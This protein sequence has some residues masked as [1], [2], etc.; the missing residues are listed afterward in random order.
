MSLDILGP[1]N[2]PNAVTTRPVD[3]RTGTFG[4]ADSWMK[5]CSSAT[6]NDGTKLQ[7]GLFNALLGQ[8]RNLVRG[9][10]QT[11]ASADVVTQDNTDDSMALKAVQHL[12]QRGQPSYALDTSVT[13]GTITVALSPAPPEYKAGMIVRVK[14]ANIPTASTQINLN[15]L[16]NK[17][18]VKSG[19]VAL[20]G[21]EW[22]V[23]DIVELYFDGTTFYTSAT[24]AS[25]KLTANRTIYINASTGS[26]T[27]Y[28]G[29]AA[30]VS[31]GHGPLATL[32]AAVNLAFSYSPS[33]FN[34]TVQIAAGTYT[35]CQTPGYPGPTLI[36]QGASM[37]SVI[38]GGG[39]AGSSFQ[40][41]GQNSMTVN[42]AT[43]QNS[44]PT[45]GQPAFSAVSGSTLSTN[46]T[47]N[48]ACGG[49][50]FEA[51]VG[52]TIT[53][54]NHTFNGGCYCLF[55][56]QGGGSIITEGGVSYVI[57]VSLTPTLGYGIFAS[58]CGTI[59]L[60]GTPP[61]FVGATNL[62]GGKYLASANGVISC[63]GNGVNY[64]PGSAAGSLQ[65]GGQITP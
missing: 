24:S 10:G 2:A 56:A 48:N 22:A 17:A 43:V 59:T 4:A 30:T 42:N 7:A 19:G 14:M 38:V 8:L 52:A 46:N 9:N 62:V 41:A 15:T 58:D 6:A 54:G 3:T 61:T 50:V 31:G 64:W 63:T 27:L 23:G 16:G 18:V 28:D 49:A 21:T 12:I 40:V 53:P 33:Q 20:S 1:A 39:A 44:N 36:F 11:A 35:G 34:I 37:A 25:P 60:P 55:W 32:Q 26:D 29:T 57:N 13:A 5:D 47:A 45:G 65:F 51:G